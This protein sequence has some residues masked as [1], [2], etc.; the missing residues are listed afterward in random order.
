MTRGTMAIAA[1]ALPACC[2][3]LSAT[4]CA[5][6]T[7]D[8]RLARLL[9]H[10]GTRQGAIAEVSAS[11][12]NKVSLLLSW[13]RNP[14]TGVDGYE[15][16]IGLADA[17]GKLKTREA[18]PFLIANI[19]RRRVRYVDLSPWLKTDEVI[20]NTFPALAALVQIGPEASRALIRA[21]RAPMPPED[22]LAAIFVVSRVEGV[23]EAR[24]F[25]ASALGY[26]NLE[27]DRAARGLKFLSQGR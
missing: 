8:R 5:Q 4:A 12:S 24:D 1:V 14:P 2:V 19:S 9:A 16:S 7:Q 21:A 3:L 17:F 11:G 27:R 20:E 23:P 15:L 25:L 6:R 10:E 26:A 18:I 13:A 22:R